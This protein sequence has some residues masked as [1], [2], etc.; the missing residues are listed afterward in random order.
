M[1]LIAKTDH[2]IWT[3]KQ[4]FDWNSLCATIYVLNGW[5]N[6]NEWKCENAEHSVLI[7]LSDNTTNTNVISEVMVWDQS[8]I[9]WLLKALVWWI[10]FMQAWERLGILK[11]DKVGL[12]AYWKYTCLQA[13]YLITFENR[14]DAPLKIF[15]Q[16]KIDFLRKFIQSVVNNSN[17]KNSFKMSI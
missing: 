13:H 8:L 17:F 4:L 11:V 6:G 14:F 15:R 5:Y 16:F 3:E 12:I 2:S 10:M 9:A 7:Y 1:K